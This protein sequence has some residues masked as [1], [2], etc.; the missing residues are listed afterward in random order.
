MQ[1]CR[2][3]YMLE[4]YTPEGASGT[5]VGSPTRPVEDYEG[6]LGAMRVCGPYRE[7]TPA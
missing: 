7:S 6:L 2:F 4:T 5:G 1:I 3:V